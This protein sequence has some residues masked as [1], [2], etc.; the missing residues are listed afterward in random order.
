MMLVD[1]SHPFREQVATKLFSADVVALQASDVYEALRL[2]RGSEID[3]L[4]I[5]GDQR[6]QS[7][8]RCAGKL[9][10]RSPS[11]G[12]ILYFDHVSD[13]DRLWG[14][15]SHL[16]ALVETKGRP[17]PLVAAVLRALGRSLPAADRHGRADWASKAEGGL[18][19]N[20]LADRDQRRA[21]S[22]PH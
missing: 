10:G 6:Y 11:C 2:A 5:G 22:I 15:V 4:V 18:S 8:W 9:C 20:A 16:S 21:R 1:D 14:R 12:V 17:K 7:G 19:V 3:L 13:R